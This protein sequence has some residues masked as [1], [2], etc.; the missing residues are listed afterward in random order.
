[1]RFARAFAIVA[2]LFFAL[3]GIASA[4]Y[5]AGNGPP[6]LPL[7][8]ANQ[9]WYVATTGSDSN[10]GTSG[11]PFL[12][13]Q[14]AVNVAAGYNWNNLYYPTINVADGTYASTQVTL[15][16]MVGVL[17]NSTSV[18][19]SIVGNTTTPTNVSVNDAGTG[20]TFNVEPGA[21]WNLKGFSF[22]G[23]YGGIVVHNGG[24]AWINNLNWGGA[25]AQTGLYG[26]PGSKIYDNTEGTQS[27]TFSISASTMGAWVYSRGLVVM[28]NAALTVSNAITVTAFVGLDATTSFFAAVGMTITHG[29]NVTA[30][31][32]LLMNN[33][34]F[35][36]TSS[37]TKV[38]GT[39]LTRANVPG[40]N[41]SIDGWSTFQ[42]DLATIYG[43]AGAIGL[44]G[45]DG[46]AR[47]DYGY[48][49]SN[50]WTFYPPGGD[51]DVYS[52]NTSATAFDL[53][54]TSAGG[55]EVFFGAIGSGGLFG[56]SAG[57]TGFIDV[58]SGDIL[59]W[60][61]TTGIMTLGNT[62]GFSAQGSFTANAADAGLSRLGAASLALGNGTAGD[63]T[64]TLKLAHLTASSLA[65][66][67]TTSAVCYNTSTGVLTYDGT[68]GTCTT[69]DERLKNM[70]APISNALAK[71]LQIHGVNY[72]WKAPQY[73]SGPQI[74]VGAQTV[75]RVFPELVQTGSDGYKSVDYQRLTA[76]II[77]ALRELKADNDNLRVCQSSWKCRIFGWR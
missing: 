20:Y 68:V 41:V 8:S 23:T 74:G 10:P 1:M 16:P 19:S 38:D 5:G 63:F 51:L 46:A 7:A 47:A 75:E 4:Q 13:I 73:G 28:D 32:G 60:F 27:G 25:L 9:T 11:S 26:E 70:G 43:T 50:N 17:N 36:E 3:T 49:N 67:A 14:H 42:P 33:G 71:L 21:L 15:P 45:T 34:A 72:T 2:T 69:S 31:N 48:T 56:M 12:T 24:I 62:L 40:G 18:A 66:T 57:Q 58:T 64:G 39:L 35:Y 22:G 30:T 77:E 6:G 44:A 52:S 54:N 55:H 76:P 61:T 59:Y 65:N 53:K 29:S 37:T